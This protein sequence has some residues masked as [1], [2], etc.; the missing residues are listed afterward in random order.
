MQDDTK[1][2]RQ[3]CNEGR[4]CAVALVQLGLELRHEENERLLQA[5]S[6]LCGGV[7]SKLLCGALT[8]A[9]C[10]MNVL[11]PV[12]ANAF[13]VPELVRWFAA[14]FGEEYGGLN[15]SDILE[16]DA[17][18]KTDRCPALIEATYLKAKEI[19]KKHGRALG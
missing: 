18:N 6:A 13:A 10:M 16:G 8:G 4:C 12:R 19:L 14:T 11:D 1:R 17:S 3:L 9:A 5:A 15:C 7:Q 2:L